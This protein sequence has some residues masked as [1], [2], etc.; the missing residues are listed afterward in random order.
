MQHTLPNK[1]DMRHVYLFE[2]LDDGELSEVIK[3]AHLIRLAAHERLFERGENAERFYLLCSGQ[4][5]LF[6]VSADGYEKIF[7][8]IQPGQTFAEAIM[9]MEQHRYPVSVEAILPSELYSFD[10]RTFRNILKKS[11]ETCFR[12]MSVMSQRLHARIREINSLT[13]QN[14][15]YRLVNYLLDQIP[16][17]APER[18]AIHL[19]NQKSIIASQLSIQPETFSRIL[20]RLTKKG[21]ISVSRQDISV[22]SVKGLREFLVHE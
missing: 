19:E 20:S 21:I 2:S 22:H 15:T 6:Q 18:P 1:D 17:E 9:F 8:I 7:E 13:L 5:K 16:D 4:V 11:N 10:M 3:S 12:L 14:A